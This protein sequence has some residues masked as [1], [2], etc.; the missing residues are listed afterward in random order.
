MRNI[1][2]SESEI[3]PWGGQPSELSAR[4]V[5]KPSW[6]TDSLLSATPALV[7]RLTNYSFIFR[8]YFQHS[9]SDSSS[10][11]VRSSSTFNIQYSNTSRFK[12]VFKSALFSKLNQENFT[13]YI[14][15]FAR[16]RRVENWKLNG[17]GLP[18]IPSLLALIPVLR[19]T[20]WKAAAHCR[21]WHCDHAGQKW[22][23]PLLFIMCCSIMNVWKVERAAVIY[24][25]GI[26]GEQ[27]VVSWA[28]REKSFS[29]IMSALII[30]KR[31]KNSTALTYWF[32][33]TQY[34]PEIFV[35][36]CG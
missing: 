9:L 16:Q 10:N 7:D 4:S 18:W 2:F 26:R 30:N 12:Q 27:A 5:R 35:R 21:S 36:L 8:L 6:I 29:L 19:C 14:T 3:W 24:F 1:H 33:S 13:N 25:Q 34:I 11:V 23:T 32:N 17:R 22:N 20:V 31:K 15:L 28:L